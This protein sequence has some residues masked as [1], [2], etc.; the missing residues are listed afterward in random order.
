MQ[1]SHA[2]SEYRYVMLGLQSAND[3]ARDMTSC[4]PITSK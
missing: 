1:R 4:N 3:Q 2:L